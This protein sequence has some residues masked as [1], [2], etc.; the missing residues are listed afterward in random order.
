VAKTEFSIDEVTAFLRARHSSA[1]AVTLLSGGAWS[2][3]YRFTANGETF[4]V[5]FGRHR[6]DYER[7]ALAGTWEL[8]DAPT[9]PVLEIGDAFDDG[10]YCIAPWRT[11]DGFDR[12]SADRFPHALR[13]VLRAYEAIA[14]VDMPGTG[15]GIWEGPHG[16]APHPT[17]ESFLTG[18]PERDD[19]RLRGWRDRL[20][21]HPDAHDVFNTAQHEIE[22][23][24]PNCGNE[25]AVNH[26]DPLWTNI[27]IGPDDRVTAFLDW[28]TS[29]VGDPLYDVAMLLF[30]AP[31][32]AGLKTHT[33]VIRVEATRRFGTDV[34]ERLRASM[35]HIGI[36]AMQYQA[37]AGHTDFLRMT[38]AWVSQIN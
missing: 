32:H 11:G 21:A 2:A 38:A 16:N 15:F 29:I 17:W 20:S 13:N 26:C 28:G 31:F 22:R 23:L 25:R 4:V 34:D 36:A 37:F 12:I 6:D 10:C 33:D 27:L 3:A 18:V 9:P 1:D 7:D 5:K 24:A 35:L 8:P 30:C 14:A 19:E